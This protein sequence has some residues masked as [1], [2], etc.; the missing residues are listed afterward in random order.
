MLKSTARLIR[1]LLVAA[2]CGRAMEITP[3]DIAK[4]GTLGLA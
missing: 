3:Q 4:L 1:T 2:G